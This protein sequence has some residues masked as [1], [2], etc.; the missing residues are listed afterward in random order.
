[1]NFHCSNMKDGKTQ[2][3]TF[4][5]IHCIRTARRGVLASENIKQHFCD[6]VV[7][8]LLTKLLPN[9]SNL[10]LYQKGGLLYLFGIHLNDE[11]RT[12]SL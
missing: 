2:S 4:F 10:E 9:W 8:R 11:E 1:M 12:F 5:L 3:S 6:L 7:F